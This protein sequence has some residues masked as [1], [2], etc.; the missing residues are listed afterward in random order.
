MSGLDT[1]Q[2]LA[3]AAP[4]LRDALELRTIL[5]APRPRHLVKFT[6]IDR[7]SDAGAQA[8]QGFAAAWFRAGFQ[9]PFTMLYP[10]AIGPGVNRKAKTAA[11]AFDHRLHAE[12]AICR[13]RAR[14]RNV[15]VQHRRRSA[16]V[17]AAGRQRNFPVGGR[18]Q[19]G[20]AGHRMVGEPA[21]SQD[22]DRCLVLRGREGRFEPT[23]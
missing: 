5:H 9:P 3:I 18:R 2:R 10:G 8:V 15:R 22:A 11:I 21:Q 19:Q 12:V 14:L 17:V 6:D 13:Q 1:R 7:R 23:P 16:E 20:L 4:Q